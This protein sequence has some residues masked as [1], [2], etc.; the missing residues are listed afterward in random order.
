[1]G[2]ASVEG[3]SQR[4]NGFPDHVRRVLDLYRI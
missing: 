4:E 2:A 1:M 3:V